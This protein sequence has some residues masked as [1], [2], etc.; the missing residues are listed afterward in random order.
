[1]DEKN[2]RKY[3]ELQKKMTEMEQNNNQNREL[4]MKEISKN[5]ISQ[6][7]NGTINYCFW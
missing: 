2:D 7:V 4:L 1:M 3:E 6:Y 5:I